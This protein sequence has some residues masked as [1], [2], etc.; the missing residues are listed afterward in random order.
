MHDLDAERIRHC[1]EAWFHCSV[2]LEFCL[3]DDETS[4]SES[5]SKSFCSSELIF[6]SQN[7][8]E[9]APDPGCV[10]QLPEGAAAVDGA[11]AC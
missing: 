1:E 2:H 7:T 11:M 3:F 6:G 9:A 4:Q 5:R 8:S 10:I